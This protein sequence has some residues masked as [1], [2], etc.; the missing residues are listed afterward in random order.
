[1]V[2]LVGQALKWQVSQKIIDSETPCD[3][4]TGSVPFSLAEEDEPVSYPLKVIKL[5]K[6]SHAASI[7][8]SPDAKYFC[9][10]VCFL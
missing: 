7:C 1:L 3:L 10:T 9:V 6:K 2:T 4:L 5:P 8:F